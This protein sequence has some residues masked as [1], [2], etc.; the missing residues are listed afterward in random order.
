VCARKLY[1][2]RV[3]TLFIG[4]VFLFIFMPE[5]FEYSALV[6][7]QLWQGAVVTVQRHAESVE[8]NQDLVVK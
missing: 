1:V 3:A 8:Q 6:S 2:F 5:S 7:S 4:R